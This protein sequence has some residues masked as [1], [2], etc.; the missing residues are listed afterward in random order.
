MSMYDYDYIQ[1]WGNKR[2]NCEWY[3]FLLFFSAQ[4]TMH[5]RCVN[6]EIS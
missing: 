2:K 3:L 5:I 1:Q 4:E 6:R